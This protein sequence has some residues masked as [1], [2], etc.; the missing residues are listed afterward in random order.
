MGIFKCHLIPPICR[1]VQPV[2]K[3]VSKPTCTKKTTWIETQKSSYYVR[4]PTRHVGMYSNLPN[5]CSEKTRNVLSSFR[6]LLKSMERS[7]MSFEVLF[8]S[9]ERKKKRAISEKFEV[10]LGKCPSDSETQ[11]NRNQITIIRY[12][13]IHLRCI[14]W[15]VNNPFPL[16]HSISHYVTCQA[17]P[18]SDCHKSLATSCWLNR[19]V[20][21]ERCSDSSISNLKMYPSIVLV[22]H[23]AT[24]CIGEF[25]FY[26]FICSNTFLTMVY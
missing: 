9:L 6:F 16:F 12:T 17:E 21:E 19:D 18:L 24:L 2:Q 11:Q 3:A 7:L 14:C 5:S 10:E 13:V 1:L 23:D 8:I 15:K 25:K 20:S 4:L 26:I 22:T